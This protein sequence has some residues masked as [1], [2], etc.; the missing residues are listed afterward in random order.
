VSI[1]P[2]DGRPPSPLTGVGR[3]LEGLPLVREF[4]GSVYIRARRP[5][6]S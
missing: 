4:S 2:F 3:L 6:E 1:K 5:V